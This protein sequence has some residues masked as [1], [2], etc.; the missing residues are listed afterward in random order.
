MISNYFIHNFK[1]HAQSSLN[2]KHLTLLTGTN[3][4]GKSSV[5]QSMLLLRDSFYRSR[6]LDILYLK[7]PSFELGKSFDAI[8]ANCKER[9]QELEFDINELKFIYKYPSEMNANS[10]KTLKSG[11]HNEEDL[12]KISLFSN[13]FQYLSA[14]REG[15]QTSYGSDTD[16]VDDQKQVSSKM[17]WGDMAV[18]F[19]NRFGNESLPI[20]DLCYDKSHQD[21]LKV[22]TELWMNDISNGLRIKIDQNKDQYKLSLGYQIEGYTTRYFSATN[23]G[24]GISYVLSVVVAVLSA[25]PG[26]LLL[27]ENPEAHIHPSGQAALMRL[28]SKAAAAGVQIIIETH[29]DHIVNGTLVNRKKGVLHDDDL[30]IYYFDKDDF[31]N[32]RPLAL[33]IANDGRIK[34]AP[35][36]FFDQMNADLD[37]LFDL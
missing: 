14:F 20:S 10:L 1:N 11:M 12:I 31:F 19:L 26:A 2:F 37:I 9:P 5:I 25:K 4:A 23:T 21:T 13:D 24:F 27:I 7:G 35:Q 32:A 8:N 3:G 36:G 33:T 17:G 16:I 29:S 6:N 34:N 18:Y 30:S 15:P 22:Q 28:I